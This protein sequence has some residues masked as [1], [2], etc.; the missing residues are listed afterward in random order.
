MENYTGRKFRTVFIGR[1]VEN[2]EA[3]MQIVEIC[4]QL[5]RYSF[6]KKTEGNVSKRSGESMLITAGGSNLSK[7]DENQIVEVLG[8]RVGKNEILAKGR[9]EPSSE[10][11]M[12]W[13]IY[14]NFP[15]AGGII[16][17][18]DP[19]L[20][21][22]PKILETPIERPYG[23]MELA[24]EAIGALKKIKFTGKKAMLMRLKN[25]G[26]LCVG[27][28]LSQDLQTL[29]EAKSEFTGG[30]PKYERVKE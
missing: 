15:E 12:H 16:H 6:L 8:Y 1:E 3:A 7:I 9:L 18:H 25:H 20:M 10:S 4:K 29:I 2:P 14:G 27:P 11:I 17:V 21:R 19:V 26:I 23:T 28:D 24:L 5:A 22:N 30:L 13:M